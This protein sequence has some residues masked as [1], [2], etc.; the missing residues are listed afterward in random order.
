MS[1]SL[2][3]TVSI[4]NADSP[5]SVV[6]ATQNGIH[7]T[8]LYDDLAT[9]DPALIKAYQ[10]NHMQVIDARPSGILAQQTNE[11]DY[12]TALKKH[13]EGIK[14]NPL[15]AG[16][17]IL[18]DWN[19]ARGNARQWLIDAKTLIRQYSDK[20]VICGFGGDIGL[21]AKTFSWDDRLADNFSPQVCDY[22][23]WYLY[24]GYWT[25][26]HRASEFN[27]NMYGVLNAVSTSLK[28]R[29][30]DI[31]KQPLIGIVQAFSDDHY[32]APSAKNMTTQAKA[33]CA[34]G[35]SAISYWTW[36]TGEGSGQSTFMTSNAVNNGIRQG[37]VA[38]QQ[39]WAAK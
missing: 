8:F 12:L 37:I 29:G 13:L 11:A 6:K 26:T 9:R 27:W 32:L 38:C 15:I 35:A 31:A 30:W 23:A 16:F 10:D 7:L 2:L 25:G 39:I 4:F 19:L 28:K 33:Y 20:P 5:A 17:W 36:G 1:Q 18:D 22:V 21:N 14:D 24:D 3:H 34:F